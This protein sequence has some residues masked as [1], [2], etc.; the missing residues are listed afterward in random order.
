[1]A[2]NRIVHF[3]ENYAIKTFICPLILFINSNDDIKPKKKQKTKMSHRKY[4]RNVSIDC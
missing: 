3:L 4:Y 2:A 1:M